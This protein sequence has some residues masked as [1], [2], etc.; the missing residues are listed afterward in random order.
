MP[1][2]QQVSIHAPARRATIADCISMSPVPC[3]NP[4]PRT[5]GDLSSVG[6]EGGVRMFQSTPPHGGRPD[7]VL[8]TGS[9]IQ[10][11]IHAPARR[12]TKSVPLPWRQLLFQSTP[13][14]GG[15]PTR[16]RSLDFAFAFQSTLPHGGRRAAL[17]SSASFSWFQSTP[18]HGGRRFVRAYRSAH[19]LF[20]ST[21][22]HGGRP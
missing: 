20:Q 5:E 1:F 7:K 3:F 17:S 11:S 22:P 12:A 18:P 4:R 19:M 16:E 6:N 8:S 15:R 2:K 21:P 9:S 14:H 10:V 13:P